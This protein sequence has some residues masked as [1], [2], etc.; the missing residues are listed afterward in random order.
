MAP[1]AGE[2]SFLPVFA[3]GHHLGSSPEGS[4]AIVGGH[5]GVCRGCHRERWS[6]NLMDGLGWGNLSLSV[7]VATSY[8]S[9]GEGLGIFEVDT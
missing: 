1:G 6:W 5:C 8:S 2:S 7:S 4:Q 9:V 3:G